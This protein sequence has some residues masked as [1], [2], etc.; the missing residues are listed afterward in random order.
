MLN[1]AKRRFIETIKALNRCLPGKAIKRAHLV[2]GL[3][4]PRTRFNF[5]GKLGA[6][7]AEVK[8][9]QSPKS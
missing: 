1:D 6:G 7:E 8:K 5:L 2:F 3:H 9:G 4:F